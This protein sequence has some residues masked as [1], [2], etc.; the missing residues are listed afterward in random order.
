M[1]NLPQSLSSETF[2]THG[3]ERR[4]GK[5]NSTS[6]NTMS[7][8]LINRVCSIVVECQRELNKFSWNVVQPGC[9]P[10]FPNPP[11]LCFHNCCCGED[12]A[13][14]HRVGRRIKWKI[15]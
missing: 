12:S 7:C 1:M 9:K 6:C 2:Q 5:D 15:I 14:M 4:K 3:Q 10:T 8:A 13:P 11:S